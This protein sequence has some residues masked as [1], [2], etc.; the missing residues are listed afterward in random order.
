MG[1]AWT[2]VNP[3]GPTKYTPVPKG[4]ATWTPD[5]AK[6]P[7]ILTPTGKNQTPWS[8]LAG[9]QKAYLYN[10]PT[11][12]YNSSI[13]GYVYVN[14]VQNQQNTKVPTGWSPGTI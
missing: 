2:P 3:N 5:T 4:H 9:P 13:M 14:P 7:T 8:P 10:S 1:T 6:V 12:P 11:V